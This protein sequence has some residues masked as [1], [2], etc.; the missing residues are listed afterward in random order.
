MSLDFLARLSPEDRARLEGIGQAMELELRQHLL[1]RGA[2]G[3]D[4]FRVEKGQLEIVDRRSRPEVILDVLGPGELVGELAF[5]DGT[6]RS[7]D[8]F[9][10]AGTVVTRWPVEELEALLGSDTAFGARFWRAMAEEVAARLRDVTSNAVTGGLRGAGSGSAGDGTSL[11]G[12]VVSQSLDGLARVD[13][14]LRRDP[15]DAR[16]AGRV[17]ALLDSLGN[18]LGARWRDGVDEEALGLAVRRLARQVHPYLLRSTTAELCLSRPDGFAGGP[19]VLAHVLAGTPQ[20]D[21]PLGEAV[22]RWLLGLPRAAGMRARLRAAEVAIEPLLARHLGQL[23]VVMINTAQGSL[24]QR[25]WKRT[26]AG[27]GE[28]WVVEPTRD[29]LMEVDMA[30]A[31]A[32]ARMR[33]RLVHERAGDPAQGGSLR[34]LSGV[35]LVVADNLFDYLPARLAA[36]LARQLGAALG[37]RGR[38]VVT[39]TAATPDALVWSQLLEWPVVARDTRSLAAI[40]KA[41]GY[42]DVQVTAVEGAG[43]LA[44][45]GTGA[46]P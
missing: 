15:G 21:G 39:A 8:A 36:D 40:L 43:L 9:A 11:V 32:R 10:T 30:L 27:E 42:A 17:V 6:P 5:I 4:V 41:A 23:T 1:V 33:L 16:A 25:I 13:Q 46:Q 22:D 14:A 38:L 29:A 45:A 44:T 37:P 19:K 18:E 34:H 20:G 28:L 7:A 35:D 26:A 3:G 2:Q 31:T 24:L 12:A